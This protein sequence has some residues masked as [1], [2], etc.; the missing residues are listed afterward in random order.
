VVDDIADEPAPS[1]EKLARL[2]D[3]RRELD[4]LYGGG[5][6]RHAIAVALAA[7]IARFALP[8]A[9]FDDILKGMETDARGPVQAP[10]MAELELYC[11]RVAGAVGL[12]SVRIFG[13]RDAGADDFALATG[14]ALQLTNILRDVHRD[15]Q[16]WRLYLPRE[17]LSAAG[18]AARDPVDAL[19]DPGLG[20]AC[21]WL[22]ERARRRYREADAIRARMAPADAR[23]LRPAVMMTAVYRRLLERVVRHGWDGGAPVAL[24]SAE[25]LWIALRSFAAGG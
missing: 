5:A 8:R 7:P 12:Q 16:E 10:P 18:I 1:E 13:C 6:P 19:H 21:A 22:A 25:K 9:P 3:W 20:A 23:S 4:A 2:D 11:A 17:A 15:A 14:H 24:G